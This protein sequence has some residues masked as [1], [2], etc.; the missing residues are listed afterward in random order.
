M[1]HC[2]HYVPPSRQNIQRLPKACRKNCKLSSLLLKELLSFAPTYFS[3]YPY[4]QIL[5][6]KQ[7]RR[8]TTGHPTRFPISHFCFQ[9]CQPECSSPF[10]LCIQMLPVLRCWSHIHPLTRRVSLSV[11][12]E[13]FSPFSEVLWHFT[14]VLS[15]Q[16]ISYRVTTEW[17]VAW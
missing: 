1:K 4:T 2:F 15:R 14:V 11:L 17:K 6:F 5:H 12:Q 16:Q 8:L 10:S 3:K 9:S 7:Y 13:M